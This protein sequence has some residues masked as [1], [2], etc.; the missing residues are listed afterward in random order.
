MFVLPTTLTQQNALKIRE[1]GLIAL[2]KKTDEHVVSGSDLTL[3]DSTALSVL[4]AYV[5]A[6]P[7][8]KIIEAPKK[9]VSLSKVYG[10]E[11]LL[12]ISSSIE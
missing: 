1:E 6:Y 10:L 9:L 4:M 5:R 8:L 2:S 11:T 3:F 7:D 12:P